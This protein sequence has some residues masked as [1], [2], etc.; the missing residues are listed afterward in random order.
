M[1]AWQTTRNGR[2]SEVL[3]LRDDVA[4]PVAREGTVLVDVLAAGVGL[5]DFLM[6]QGSYVLTPPLPFTQGQ[7]VVGRVAGWGDDVE[8]RAIGDR[9]MAVTSFFTGNGSFAEQCL[10]LDDFC[11]PV[12]DDMT[13]AEAAAFLIPMHT[14][15]VG[16]VARARLEPGETLLVL[17]GAGGTGSAAIQ[18]GKIL[19]A[20]VIAVAAGPDKLAFCEALGAD[21]T[22][23]RKTTDLTQAVRDLTGGRGVDCVY[24]PVGGAA[25]QSATRCIA[26]EGRILLVGFA[27][28]SW[29]QVDPAHLVTQN[30]GVL[31]I[32]PSHY[33]R[34]FKEDAQDKLIAWWREGRLTASVGELVAFDALPPALERL[35]ASEIQG[36]LVVGVSEKVTAPAS[37]KRTAS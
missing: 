1:Q 25:Y 34:A 18:L 21:H 30:Y 11:L 23:D 9:V 20:T 31:G 19:G 33:D 5:P 35:G 28:G 14:A 6:C 37:T 27:S 7:E 4:P 17:G 16:L 32:I 15:W 13:D 3:A 22:I 24:D 29:G 8:N 36:K 26:P 2:P 10:A 12:P